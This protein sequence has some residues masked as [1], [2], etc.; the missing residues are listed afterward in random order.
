MATL[1][2]TICKSRKL[3]NPLHYYLIISLIKEFS[4]DLPVSSV[5][6][7]PSCILFPFL[8]INAFIFSPN[9]SCLPV[10]LSGSTNLTI[11]CTCIQSLAHICLPVTPTPAMSTMVFMMV[12]T[13]VFMMV[14][15]IL[16]RI[17]IFR[18]H[19]RK[20][21]NQTKHTSTI[22]YYWHKEYHILT[23]VLQTSC[24]LR[25]NHDF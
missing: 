14:P 12:S 7:H 23:N 22:L 9:L 1:R 20:A 13:M 8:F 19:V 11:A 16:A 25:D 6:E 17:W 21:S 2:R 15:M 24:F 3:Q 4:V 10:L 5:P 18:H